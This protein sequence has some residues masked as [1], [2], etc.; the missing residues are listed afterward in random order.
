M[1]KCFSVV[2]GK[3]LRVTRLDECGN[4]LAEGTENSL[5]VTKGFISVGL[6]SEVED[7]DDITQKNADGDLCISDRSRDQ[8]RHWSLE[9]S[10]CRVDP[11]ILEMVSHATL[12]E[13]HASEVVGVRIPEGASEESFGLE[14]WTGVPGEDCI[15]DQPTTYGYLLLPF[16]IPGAP[17]DIT[18]ENGASTFSLNARTKGGGGWGT[19]PTGYDVVPQDEQQTAGPLQT[20]IGASEHMLLRTTTIA[21]PEEQCG[22]Q[23][24]PSS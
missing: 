16:V 12:E 8:F 15:P 17:G 11:H 19:G 24:M 20:A 10:L 5:V 23:P 2:R 4:P 1:T 18:V 7:G 21:P 22:A 14:L 9:L 6:T 13:D 3:R